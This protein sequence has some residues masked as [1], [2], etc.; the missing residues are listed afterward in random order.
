MNR[1]VIKKNDRVE[2]VY[3]DDKGKIVA[4]ESIDLKT[5]EKN[6]KETE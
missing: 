2:I 1:K 3:T 5:Y 6:Y 4:H